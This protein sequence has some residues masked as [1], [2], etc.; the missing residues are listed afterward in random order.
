MP[1]W[2]QTLSRGT[3]VRTS[4]KVRIATETQLLFCVTEASQDPIYG[5]CIDGDGFA[6][7][8]KPLVLEASAVPL[9]PWRRCSPRAVHSTED[10][11]KDRFNATHAF[12][13]KDF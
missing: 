1:S 9:F 12:P 4:Q 3:T 11:I 10:Q 13:L 7:F 6:S 5:A 2:S 8:W